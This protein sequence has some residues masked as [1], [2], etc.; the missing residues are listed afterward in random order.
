MNQVAKTI[1]DASPDLLTRLI[2]RYT[3]AG[4]A[5]AAELLARRNQGQRPTIGQVWR[6]C[7]AEARSA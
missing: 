2:Y 1:R 7:E 5:R 4:V 6:R 3:L